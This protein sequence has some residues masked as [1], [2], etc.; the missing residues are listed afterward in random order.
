MRHIDNGTRS[1]RE[2]VLSARE[3]QILVLLVQGKSNRQIAA[4]LHLDQKG[5]CKVGTVKTHVS[6]ILQ[7]LGLPNR[8]AAATFAGARPGILL[9]GRA[10]VGLHPPGCDCGFSYCRGKAA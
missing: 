8:T 6:N 2:V 7:S 1:A 10:A 4:K 5:S 9:D 3:L